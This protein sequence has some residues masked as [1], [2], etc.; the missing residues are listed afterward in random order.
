MSSF[1][2]FCRKEFINLDFSH[3]HA[4]GLTAEGN[5]SCSE[6]NIQS[7]VRLDESD[8]W[9]EKNGQYYRDTEKYVSEETVKNYLLLQKMKNK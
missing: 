9:L 7:I 8:K 4:Y 1:C 3:S 5:P 6:M 2:F